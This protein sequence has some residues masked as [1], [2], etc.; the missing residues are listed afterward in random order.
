M[1]SVLPKRAVPR[2]YR[3]DNCGNQ[4]SSV[5]EAVKK[6]PSYKSRKRA[7]VQRGLEP[8]SRG[9]ATVRTRYQA[10]TSEDTGGW[11]GQRD[12]VK[13]GNSDSVIIIC[14]FDL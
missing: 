9:I 14:S 1:N 2:S 13:C 12:F 8:G 3:E 4:V 5:R 7:T 10:T 11:K 6:R